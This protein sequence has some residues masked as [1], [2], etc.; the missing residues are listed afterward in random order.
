MSPHP[1]PFYRVNVTIE[2]DG[3]E[4]H[5]FQITRF[6]LQEIGDVVKAYTAK[7]FI[8]D[9]LETCDWQ[10]DVWPS[11][12]VTFDQVAEKLAK[13]MDKELPFIG[14]SEAQWL[15]TAKNILLKMDLEFDWNG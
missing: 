2:L 6:S 3:M 10:L 9:D 14:A 15:E 12:D 7:G 5:V 11:D 13:A 1:Q 4:P 8:V